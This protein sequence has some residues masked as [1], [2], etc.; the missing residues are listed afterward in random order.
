MLVTDD[1]GRDFD[2]WGLALW[3]NELDEYDEFRET[4]EEIFRNSQ[5]KGENDERK[6]EPSGGI[7]S[8]RQAGLLNR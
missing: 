3:K 4:F 7:L 1:P 8:E 5:D 2:A 6:T